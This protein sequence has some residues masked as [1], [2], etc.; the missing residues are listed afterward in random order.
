M[1]ENKD[2]Q[3]KTETASAKRLAEARDRGQ[4]SKSQDVTTISMLFI[5]G[6]SIFIAG[7]PI[8]DGVKNL[9]KYLLTNS[10]KIEITHQNVVN[11]IT[12]LFG[13]LAEMLLPVM[14]IIFVSALIG[15]IAQVKFHFAS[16]KFTEGLDFKK[17]FNP[18]SGI[19]RIFFSGK[20]YVELLKSILKIVILGGVV[21]WVL[22][23]YSE[24]TVGLLERPFPEIG[25]FMV[26]VSLEMLIKFV[27]AYMFIAAADFFYQR[28]Q[29]NK[30]M[31]MTKQEVKEETKQMMGDPKVKAR[32][33]SLMLG[34][35]RS[36]MM[37]NIKKADVVITNPTH[38]AV[39][40]GYDKSEMS[41]PKVLAKGVDF[42]AARIRE[43]AKENNIPIIENP[44]LARTL[45]YNVEVNREI[46]ESL[47][48]TVAQV[49]AYVYSLKQK[50]KYF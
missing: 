36:F 43:E 32:F 35:I 17:I 22:S 47:F 21:Y 5:G 14:S 25:S 46:P 4:V 13:L 18:F 38:F 45:F 11:M 42:M 28:F 29:F 31:K 6:F 37:K 1:A 10:Y 44:P 48:K 30:D 16:K 49:L 8:I 40:V 33:R 24:E 15:E 41:A 34:R 7:A 2:G 39:A 27:V 50:K 23:G 19:K 12:G 26:K 20:S 3:E 9:M